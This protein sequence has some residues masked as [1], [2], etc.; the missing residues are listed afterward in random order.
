M[1]GGRDVVD[2]PDTPTVA[3]VGNLFFRSPGRGRP[4]RRRRD[5]SHTT[6]H[7][8]THTPPPPLAG[9]H[10]PRPPVPLC[11]RA[12]PTR[13]RRPP[14]LAPFLRLLPPAGP[15]PD[16]RGD[17]GGRRVG[18]PRAARCARRAEHPPAP[19]AGGPRVTHRDRHRW[20]A[21]QA[22]L[23][24]GRG[25]GEAVELW[26][27]ARSRRRLGRDHPRPVP[28]APRARPRGQAPL[29]QIRDGQDGRL[30]GL[31]RVARPAQTCALAP[32]RA[33]RAPGRP[34]PLRRH[35]WR[36]VSLR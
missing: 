35:R 2:A 10:R 24:C 1:Q 25:R 14:S 28:A 30:P 20:L 11:R 34:P 19:P 17:P 31:H 7:T 3:E 6:T 8:F 21:H 12:L 26:G 36:R 4:R 32:R 16:R 9:L 13:P 23:L 18:A 27:R 5:P 29:C 22:R 15:G 33:R